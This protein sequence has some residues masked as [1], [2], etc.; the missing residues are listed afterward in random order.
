MKSSPE[1]QITL[2]HLLI[3]DQKMIGI[4]FYP[5]KIIQALIKTLPGVK[6]SNQYEM[7]MIANNKENLDLIFRT[8][9]GICWINCSNFFTNRPIDL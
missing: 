8:F 6:W 9:K 2:K 7:V 3:Q 5:N 1:R 4:Q